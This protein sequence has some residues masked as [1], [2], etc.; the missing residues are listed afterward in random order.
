[1]N[2]STCPDCGEDLK[3]RARSCPCGWK[4]APPATGARAGSGPA[5]DP[6]YAWCSWI[7]GGE[8][9][10]EPGTCSLSTHGGGPWFC[11]GHVACS[12]PVVGGQIVDESIANRGARP[13]Y[14]HQDRRAGLAEH[15]RRQWEA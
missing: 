12:D 9:C 5:A 4:P 7:S 6:E 8:R 15:Y 2:P 13:S 14:A 1:M 11:A 3:P 10:R